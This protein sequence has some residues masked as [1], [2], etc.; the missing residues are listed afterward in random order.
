[1]YVRHNSGQQVTPPASGT[2]AYVWTEDE[3]LCRADIVLARL[4]AA[5][6]TVPTDNRIAQ[7]ARII[8]DT[9][10]RGSS[11]QT[12]DVAGF[13]AVTE[14]HRTILETYTISCALDVDAGGMAD[15]LRWLLKGSGD[16]RHDSN[17]IARNIQFELVVAAVLR[18]AGISRV[19]IAEPDIQIDGP[20]GSLGLA[21]KRLT[22]PRKKTW[23]TRVTEASGQLRRQGLNGFLAF[24]LDNQLRDLAT[25]GEERPTNDALIAAVD[26]L[27]GMIPSAA[28]EPHILAVIGF[29]T[30]IGWRLRIDENATVGVRCLCNLHWIVP[31]ERRRSIERFSYEL[32][33]KIQS[34]LGDILAPVAEKPGAWF[35][36]GSPRAGP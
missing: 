3:A 30:Q 23:Q 26:K 25:D 12:A 35:V 29:G 8:R 11:L 5:G 16:P 36:P 13:H 22:S 17:P 20:R 19:R 28:E 1:M 4:A 15:K 31:I 6:V 10:H 34:A 21:V 33:R 24:N 27:V 2:S 7:A 18:L 9:K 32:G 14:A